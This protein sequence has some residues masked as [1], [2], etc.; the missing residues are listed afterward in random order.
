MKQP[1]MNR[2]RTDPKASGR[3][4][5]ALAAII[6]LQGFCAVFFLSDV[7]FDFSQETPRDALHMSLEGL[8]ALSL[9]AGVVYL[10]IE[11]RQLLLR[12][13]EMYRGIRAAR[14]E[15]AEI[16]QRYFDDWTL[17]PSERDVALMILKGFDNEEI[18]RMRGTAAGTVRAQSARVFSK[19]Q[20]DGRP[21]L[22]SIFLEEL[23]RDSA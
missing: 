17:T 22:F 11:L 7:V 5:L 23:F 13:G 8:A 2:G 20:V 1:Q 12:M 9:V 3:R 16:M 19:A 6:A 10:V 15:I 18:A 21:Q 14:G 4:V